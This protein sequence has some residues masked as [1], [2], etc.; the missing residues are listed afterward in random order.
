MKLDRLALCKEIC[1]TTGTTRREPNLNYLAKTELKHVLS[2]ITSLKSRV[3]EL[4]RFKQKA[5]TTLTP[6]DPTVSVV[7]DKVAS[8]VV[9]P[10]GHL[11][12]SRRIFVRRER[13]PAD[14]VLSVLKP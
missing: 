14:R 2:Y 4:E 7:E 13:R 3:A 6:A 8:H 11:P 10:S 12:Q 1:R 9:E 5:V